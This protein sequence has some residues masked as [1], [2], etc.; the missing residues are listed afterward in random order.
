M[1]SIHY[2]INVYMSISK[3]IYAFMKIFAKLANYRH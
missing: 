2:A 1:L 3:I